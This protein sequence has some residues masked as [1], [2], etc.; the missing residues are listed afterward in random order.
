M[1]F[2]VFVKGITFVIWCRLVAI[3]LVV[4]SQKNPVFPWLA[5]KRDSSEDAVEQDV[6]SLA[7]CADGQIWE[8]ALSL[9]SSYIH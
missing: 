6:G 8:H 2:V 4:I 3:A 9:A 1:L 7:E 5:V